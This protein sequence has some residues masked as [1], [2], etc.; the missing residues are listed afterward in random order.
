MT[1]SFVVFISQLQFIQHRCVEYR[2]TNKHIHY[3]SYII[4]YLDLDCSKSN[5]CSN[6]F[7]H[8]DILLLTTPDSP[9]PL[10]LYGPLQLLVCWLCSVP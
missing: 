7:Y 6:S 3:Y 9:F 1:I 8:M 10:P 5:S 2:N 4:F